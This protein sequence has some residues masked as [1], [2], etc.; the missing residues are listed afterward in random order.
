MIKLPIPPL[1]ITAYTA[2]TTKKKKTSDERRALHKVLNRAR[3]RTR[4]NIGV[5]F[6]RWRELR[7]QKRI[8]S[9]AE[10]AIFLL[11]RDNDFARTCLGFHEEEESVSPL[12]RIPSVVL[13][14][15]LVP[16]LMPWPLWSG[17]FLVQTAPGIVFWLLCSW[18]HINV[19]VMSS[20][21]IVVDIDEDNFSHNPESDI[22]EADDGMCSPTEDTGDVSEENTL[23]YED[24]DYMPSE[25]VKTNGSLNTKTSLNIVQSISKEVTEDT[26]HEAA[27]KDNIQV[28][29]ILP[30]HHLE[31]QEKDPAENLQQNKE[32]FEK[33]CSAEQPSWLSKSSSTCPQSELELKPPVQHNSMSTQMHLN[34][35]AAEVN[36]HEEHTPKTRDQNRSTSP[37][38]KTHLESTS[39]HSSFYYNYQLK[40]HKE[41]EPKSYYICPACGK[42]FSQNEGLKRHLVIH[43][44]KR[45]F[46]CFTCGKRFTQSGNLKTH[47]NIHKEKHKILLSQ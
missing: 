37:A 32:Q 35:A 47:M 1:L 13:V 25:H 26:T 4:V 17:Q 11:D 41:P 29:K 31:N 33:I 44:G 3:D 16:L 10:L 45:P 28:Q 9:D 14:S 22:D 40:Q 5:A 30:H 18:P 23:Y 39:E 15:C 12:Q 8:K 38:G 34:K 19:T 27:D 21:E 43:S 2:K 24:R 20:M 7:K 6:S 46:K 42:V 36:H